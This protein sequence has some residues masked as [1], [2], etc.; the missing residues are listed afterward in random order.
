[1]GKRLLL[2]E[3]EA[4]LARAVGRLLRR[5]GY[6]VYL[7]GT[8]DEARRAAGRF[9]LGVF[10]LDLP[11]GDGLELAA[12]LSD[13][14]AV[15][16]AVFFSGTPDP[17]RR[18]DAAKVGPFVEKAKGFPALLATIELA[19]ASAHVRVAGADVLLGDSSSPPP[20]GV[21]RKPG[22]E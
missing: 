4:T 22:S 11:D 6:E 10:D 21:S 16:R 19:L 9:S 14:G 7:A 3:D 18:D 17:V 13:L 1:M 15:R 20:S 5:A 8:C 2:V 12:E